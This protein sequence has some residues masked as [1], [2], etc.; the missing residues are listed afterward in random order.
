MNTYFISKYIAE[1][2]SLAK[3]E[4][5]IGITAY[6]IEQKKIYSEEHTYHWQK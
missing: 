6:G 1:N 5:M 3:I 4:E 2:L